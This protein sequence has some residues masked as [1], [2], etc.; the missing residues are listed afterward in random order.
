MGLAAAQALLVFRFVIALL[1]WK[2]RLVDDVQAP[3]ASVILCLRGGDP[4][5]AD[6]IKGLLSQ[7]YPNFQVHVVVDHKDDPANS[8]LHSLLPKHDSGDVTIH[9][10]D[11]S[12]ETCSLKCSSVVQAVRTLDRSCEFIA[13]LDADT[14]PHRTWLRE[15]ATALADD[16]VGAA[17]GNRWY[18][19]QSVTVGSMVRYVWNAAAVVQMHSYE[20]AWGGT[21][22]VKMRVLRETN[23]LDKWSTAFCEDTMLFTF[24]RNENLRVAFVPSLMMVNRESCDL[25]GFFRWVCRQ[26]LTAKL[27][28][29][30]WLA[31]LGHG[32]ITTVVPVFT[33][34][35]LIGAALVG[36]ATAAIWLF[37]A[38][39]CYQLA[40]TVIL[41]PMEYAI[42]KIVSSRGEQ[43]DWMGVG[44]VCLF[45]AAVPLTQLV[46]AAAL[47]STSRLRSVIWRGIR[48]DIAGPWN[49]KRGAYRPY[50]SNA[51]DGS[52]SI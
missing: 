3:N 6:C 12:V 10:L 38:L 35:L 41:L 20:I 45:L 30:A 44:G 8:I 11:P 51:E 39:A 40:I 33:L 16:R 49:I 18:M 2:R 24:L 7:D 47:W 21:L 17:S 42:R 37:A 27:Y 15:L 22:A 9:Y 13:Q 5:L 25:G 1:R 46:Y 52:S 29:P 34:L 4:F 48:Y 28:H 26:L 19:P 32:I 43:K 36:N 50:Q 31:V 23:L 14:V